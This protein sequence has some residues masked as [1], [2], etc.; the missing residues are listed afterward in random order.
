MAT[1]PS[2]GL[3]YPAL[4]DPPNGPAQFQSLAAAV[5]PK[6][7]G[8]FA[9]ATDRGTKVGTPTAGMLAFLKN[10][11]AYT[12]YN[13][14]SWVPIGLVGTAFVQQSPAVSIAPGASN[15][16]S[17]SITVPPLATTL[18]GE[19]TFDLGSFFTGAGS[20]IETVVFYSG[21]TV[22]GQY[23]KTFPSTGGTARDCVSAPFSI[24][25]AAGSRAILC[26]VV[27]HNPS[28]GASCNFYA[29]TF[30]GIYT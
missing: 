1:T 17:F 6:L 20:E 8:V 21:G 2:Q 3:P 24:P 27:N 26:R 12:W 10:P 4:T 25:V 23:W 19:A 30:K 15:S 16:A 28:G 9:D 5:E 18:V 14:S 13:G 11:G 7:V 29:V 22:G